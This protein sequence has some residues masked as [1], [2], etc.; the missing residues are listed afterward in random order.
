MGLRTRILIAAIAAALSSGGLASGGLSSRASA[1]PMD[2]YG[3]GS[4]SIAMGGAVTADVSD[5]SANYYNPAGLI[6][7]QEIRIGLG[8]F[9][10]QS[11]LQI[12]DLDS[13]I[14]PVSGMVMGLVVPGNIDGFRFAFGL[15]VH[16]PD[17]R[18]SRTRS[19]PR[20]RPRWEF[21]DNRPQR[22][23][24]A[25]HI[26]VRPFD[27]L[28]IGGG[29]AFLSYAKNE[30]AIRGDIDVL[31]PDVGTRAEHEVQADLTTIR[32]PQ[33]G[34]QIVP[35]DALSFGI[36]YRGQFALSNDLRAEVG[37]PGETSS[38]RL[39]V[40]DIAI[41]GYFNLVSQSV[42]AFVPQ[43]LSVAASWQPIPELRIS[44]ELTWV[45][46]S[47][48]I[49]PIGT[50]DILLAIRVPPE[51]ADRIRVPDMISGSEPV[52][53]NFEDRFVP[54]LGVEGLA[55]SER[56]L[57]VT[58]RGGAFYESSPVPE[59]QGVSNLI[60]T[61]RIALSLG[62]GLRLTE[63]RPLIDGWLSFD[64]HLQWSILPERTT[65]KASPVDPVGDWRAGGHFFQG[66]LS[67]EIAFR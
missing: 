5:F 24:L 25:T 65:R 42:N 41:P 56:G 29:I 36:V 67:M 55:L 32:Y 33:V 53:A 17:E 27:W 22:T 48:Y 3:L 51:L 19:L 30:L 62:G 12:D 16:L 58:I 61:D 49:S 57:D 46:W 66:G 63:L 40:G 38:T 14:D 6:R 26:A 18:V 1:Q 8:W 4:R 54:R 34:I 50:A 52:A 39:L 43:Q 28:M 20:T 64:L 23:Y 45:N 35:M 59:Q 44:A 11:E 60:D 2:T 15:S 37:S 31:R 10:V 47:A 7:G 13:N 21:Y 9:G